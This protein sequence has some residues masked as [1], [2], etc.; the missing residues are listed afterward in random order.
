ME[1]LNLDLQSTPNIVPLDLNGNNTDKTKI[2][3]TKSQEI[4]PSLELK[5]VS[6]Q[7][8][9]SI[10]TKDEITKP[11]VVPTMGLDL[12]TDKKKVIKDNSSNDTQSNHRDDILSRNSDKP[13]F[14]STENT[15]DV[16]KFLDKNTTPPELNKKSDN[17]SNIDIASLDLHDTK[18]DISNFDF[19]PEKKIDDNSSNGSI[20]LNAKTQFEPNI[21]NV[22]NT[23]PPPPSPPKKKNI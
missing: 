18:N 14:S 8:S 23:V 5:K 22:S 3:I 10:F 4:A 6:S 13:M 15:D 1:E 2:T 9:L 20:D 16:L 19:F 11:K 17:M 7:P 12:L 21:P